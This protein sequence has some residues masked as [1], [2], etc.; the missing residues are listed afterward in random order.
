[1]IQRAGSGMLD[2]CHDLLAR[3]SRV[4]A[5]HDREAVRALDDVIASAL[6]ALGPLPIKRTAIEEGWRRGTIGTE[7]A[8]AEQTKIDAEERAATETIREAEMLRRL[9]PSRHAPRAVPDTEL[10]HALDSER[11][12]V[13]ALLTCPDVLPQLPPAKDFFHPLLSGLVTAS[14]INLRRLPEWWPRWQCTLIGECLIEFGDAPWTLDCLPWHAR[15]VT[16]AAE[17]RRRLEAIEGEWIQILSE[18]R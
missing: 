11:L 14:P 13:G 10:P 3:F 17:A 1:M 9:W 16:K 6:R 18:C 12:L 5:G 8:N 2:S 4:E 7:R 15:R